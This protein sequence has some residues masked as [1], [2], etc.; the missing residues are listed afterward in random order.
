MFSVLNRLIDYYNCC[1]VYVCFLDL[2]KEFDRV[3]HSLLVTKLISINAPGIITRILQ[4]WYATQTFIVQWGNCLSAPFTGTNGVRQGGI[5]SPYLFD[6][7]TDDL[8]HVL[9][10]TPYGCYVNGQCFNHLTHADDT[11]L[12][13]PSLAA[14]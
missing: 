8:S 11:L 2:S 13:A 4:A 5:L 6:V 12:L 3:D 10:N 7:F 9:R 1:P 14:L